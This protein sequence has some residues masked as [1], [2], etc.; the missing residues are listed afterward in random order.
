MNLLGS[1]PLETKRLFLHQTEE[2]NLKALWEILCL[3]EV[4]KY[5]LT[6]KINFSWE[7]EEKWQLKKL[8]EAGNNNVFRWT[9]ELKDTKEVIGQI[10]IQENEDNDA[11][12]IRDIGWFIN[13][14]YQRQGYC[15]EAAM[16]VLKY[17]F[18]EVE[19]RAIET[20]IAKDNPASWRL[21]EK[22]GFKKLPGKKKLK[23]TFLENEVEG[24]KYR[25][26]KNDFLK[27]YFRKEKLYITESI[28]KDPYIKHITDDNILNLTG[29]SGSG[30]STAAMK[31][32]G[33]PNCIIIDT[34]QV[35][36]NHKKDKNNEELYNYLCKKYVKLPDLC[37]EFDKVYTEIVN[38][39]KDK[40]K[41]IIIDSAQFR[42]MS[43]VSLLKGD[44]IIIRTCINTCYQRCIDRFKN[45]KPN[46][47][48]EELS[49]YCTKKKNIY[50]WYHKLNSFIDKVDKL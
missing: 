32:H 27:E 29:E 28:D 37:S 10:S 1:K 47:T 16:E 41:M 21:I 38:Y 3:A 11:I 25:L 7:K 50:K 45:N 20:A 2:K 5:Y 46:A 14:K 23:Y 4:N 35:F 22:I 43:D 15:Y 13:P 42:N 30:K 39:Y 49:A 8:E 17:M 36:G 48:F 6:T 34:D 24:I 26:T 18:L 19:I 44:I 31:Y 9:I 40:D 33:D 12:D